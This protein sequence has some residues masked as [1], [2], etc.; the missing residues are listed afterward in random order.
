MDSTSLLS[1]PNEILLTIFS[2][3]GRSDALATSSTSRRAYPLAISRV[4]TNVYWHRND[5][6]DE[7]D[8]SEAHALSRYM[9][10][11]EPFSQVPRVQH[12]R[13]FTLHHFCDVDVP[14]LRKLLS[15]ASNLRTIVIH[16]FEF[17]LDE[18]AL[19]VEAIGAM[20]NL[21]QA[22]LID[23]GPET[24]AALP[25]MLS[26]RYLTSL[27]L[28]FDEMYVE[29]DGIDLSALVSG[30]ASMQSLH[31]LALISYLVLT[32]PL[33]LPNAAQTILPSIRHLSFSR[34]S[35][36]VPGI[37]TLCP[38]I[39]S[40]SLQL[41]SQTDEPV[42]LPMADEDRWPTGLKQL[43]VVSPALILSAR[44]I[45]QVGSL[46]FGA[47]STPISDPGLFN[48]FLQL[49]SAVRPTSLEL[50][51]AAAM[52]DRECV[53]DMLCGA[54]PWLRSLE[55]GIAPRECDVHEYMEP[56][57]AALRSASL[58]LVHLSLHFPPITRY[59]QAS[60]SMAQA[61]AWRTTEARRAE[62]LRPLPLRL[63]EAVP[64]L[65]V[66]SL[67]SCFPRSD[68]AR[69]LARR[70]PLA[71]EVTA[72]LAREDAVERRWGPTSEFVGPA[73]RRLQV[74]RE[75]VPRD[76]RWWW[77]EGDGAARAPVEIWREAGER[78]RELIGRAD[79]D[80]ARS[81]DGFY[82]AK[83]RYER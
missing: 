69:A 56:L 37:I 71:P 36:I 78:A 33:R 80:P 4:F 63:V 32:D 57:L 61:D 5:E 62:A 20:H 1:L 79:F 81:L 35:Q 12:L 73:L 82:S 75:E 24:V 29:P 55:I 2:L 68:I 44:R 16:N 25:K 19:L 13:H 72:E 38:N 31:T 15:Q 74:L 70:T 45:G 58:A 42:V 54:A 10:A 60:L 22:S 43:N 40:L 26:S 23:V 14:P 21:E 51:T 11:P 50:H 46:A 7:E 53:W 65:R 83:C 67:S 76:K 49:L 47:S 64:T 28:E 66:L 8:A 48:D 9:C 30:L 17:F 6:V 39:I 27:T 59:F 77:V 52:V 41:Y 34:L 18:D 3:L